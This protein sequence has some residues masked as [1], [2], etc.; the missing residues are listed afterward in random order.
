[1]GYIG[2]LCFIH[3]EIKFI[4]HF[5]R[6]CLGAGIAS[7]TL[8]IYITRLKF[9]SNIVIP[10][11]TRNLLNLSKSIKGNISAVFYPFKVNLQSA[12]WRTQLWKIFI[13]LCH[14]SAKKRGFLYDNY[15]RAC[16]SSLNCCCKPAKAPPDY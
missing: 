14:P 11:L 8:I 4:R 3:A 1:M 16:F 15:I 5:N 10:L 2:C 7:Y 12:V 13:K 6:A 9:Y